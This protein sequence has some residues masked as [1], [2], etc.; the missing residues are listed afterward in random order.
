MLVYFE[1]FINAPV[2]S[3]Q[4]GSELARTSKA[5]INPRNLSIIAFELT[6]KLLSQ[7]PSFLTVGDIRE[8]GPLGIIIDS[9]DEIVGL[10]DIIKIKEIYEY[11]FELVGLKVVDEQN[12]AIGKINDYSVDNNSFV[13]QQIKVKLP[14]LKSFGDTELLIHRSQIKKVTDDQVTVIQPTVKDTETVNGS[15]NSF[16]NPF[17]KN[18]TSQTESSSSS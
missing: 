13:I 14:L 17:R 3:L 5:I 16:N 9:A 2:M 18:A 11:N 12:K 6:G 7:Q 4:T 8:V 1:R 10:D 15:M